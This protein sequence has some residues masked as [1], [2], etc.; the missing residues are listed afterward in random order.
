LSF[1]K[2]RLGD[3]GCDDRQSEQTMGALCAAADCTHHWRALPFPTSHTAD[4]LLARSHV[5]ASPNVK[6]EIFAPGQ[7]PL[8]EMSRYATRKHGVDGGEQIRRDRSFKNKS[9]RPRFH[10]RQFRIPFV[11]DAESDQL[12][13]REV[14][15]DSAN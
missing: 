15:P 8:L 9:I 2:Q 3:Q 11:V 10:R 14:A 7:H 4:E 12:Q 5:S 1:S 6:R 13:L